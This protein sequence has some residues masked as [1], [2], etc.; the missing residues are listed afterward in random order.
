MD[1]AAELAGW[2]VP[3][4]VAVGLAVVAYV[5]ASGV[6][7]HVICLKYLFGGWKAIVP[8]VSA[9]P[10]ALGVFLLILVFAI[11]DGFVEKTRQMIR[12]TLSDVIVDASLSGLPYY[13]EYIE[14]IERMPDVEGATPVIRTYAIC[15]IKP[16]GSELRLV[17]P[18]MLIGVKPAEKARMGRFLQYLQRQ[19][20]DDEVA[21]EETRSR[22]G[23]GVTRPTADSSDPPALPTEPP[24]DPR[25]LLEVPEP[26][27]EWRR[28][29][30]LPQRPGAIA[31]TGLIG[32][33]VSVE[34]EETLPAAIGLRVLSWA[35]TAAAAVAALVVW[36]ASRRRPGRLGWTV[37]TLCCGGGTV[38]LAFAAV[39]LQLFYWGKTERVTWEKVIDHPLIAYGEDFV[40]GTIPIR[41]SGAMDLGPGGIPKPSYQQIVLVD[42]FKSGYWESDSTHLYVDFEVGQRMAGMAAVPPE[43]DDPGRPARAS[44]V[45]IR[46]RPGADAEAVAKEIHAAWYILLA[47]KRL[48]DPPMVVVNTWET[49][50]RTVL[51]VVRMERDITVL[52]LGV[53][54]IGF[55]I[56]TSLI[57]YV[58]V[59]IKSRDVGI[60]KAVGASDAGVGSLFLG[61]GFVIGAMGT[62]VGLTLALLML[63]YLD[64]IETYVNHV[65]DREVFP[66]DV[67]YFEQIPRTLSAAWAAGVCIG[68]LA[69]STL[70]SLAGGLLAALKQP[71]E[72]LRYE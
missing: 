29:E 8:I 69:L 4:A 60:M 52:M 64:P 68:V 71:V 3:A 63:T 22:R 27:R 46:L 72:T 39:G 31:G 62:A 36:R 55:G 13:D 41:P 5:L 44:Q 30:G 10:A 53:M 65:L 45:Q 50:Q 66:R 12:G 9:L 25:K 14:R 47:G 49:Q 48:D 34:M 17:R 61:Y 26:L 38:L 56:L 32:R 21:S 37:A 33:P 6:Y 54:L 18:C 2:L 59:F 15:R 58:M 43:G 42:R 70:A 16:P 67:Y 23:S 57:S 40:A 51:G 35:V 20:T 28:K 19:G 1:Q 11:M 7:K 24:D